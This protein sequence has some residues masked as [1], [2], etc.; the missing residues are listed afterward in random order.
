MLIK[1]TQHALIK[2][3]QR[4]INQQFVFETIKNP[5]LIRPNY[6]FRQE[7]Y[8]KFSKNYMKLQITKLHFP[9]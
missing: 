7:F 6:G 9:C 5:E 8:M 4:K 2:L 1:F 3:E